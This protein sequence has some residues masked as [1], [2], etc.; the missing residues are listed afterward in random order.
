MRPLIMNF[1][2]CDFGS[3]LISAVIENMSLDVKELC[4]LTVKEKVKLLKEMRLFTRF[5]VDMEEV[6]NWGDYGDHSKPIIQK[7]PYN[8][9]EFKYGTFSYIIKLYYIPTV[10]S[11]LCTRN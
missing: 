2:R 3:Q 10:Q 1:K 7:W 4:D 8:P 5:N 6:H 9:S 11:A